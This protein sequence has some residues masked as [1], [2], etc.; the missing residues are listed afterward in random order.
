MIA[1]EYIFALYCACISC[2][3]FG[4]LFLQSAGLIAL[5]SMFLVAINIFVTKS[6]TIFDF[7]ATA[8]DSLAVGIPLTLNVIQEHYGAQ[9]SRRA[10]WISFYTAA[11]FVCISVLHLWYT[12]SPVDASQAH[13]YALLA[14]VPRI[15]A[16]S[17][18]TFVI[19]QYIDRY[20]YQTLRPYL[21]YRS[22]F[23]ANYG[24]SSISQAVDTLL[25]GFLGLYG[26]MENLLSIMLVS[27]TVKLATLALT[28]PFTLIAREIY[29]RFARTYSI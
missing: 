17:F 20:L 15:I 4:A 3:I 2:S 6:I 12:P 23:I 9:T 1:N 7:T 13:F 5:M 25:F 14:P 16:A 27:Y 19:A 24:A 26:I 21:T 8:A 10:I 29:R 18:T 11:I 22:A 28:A